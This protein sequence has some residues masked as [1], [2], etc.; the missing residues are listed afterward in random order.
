MSG[1]NWGWIKR[2][3]VLRNDLLVVC[4]FSQT[5]DHKKRKSH[6]QLLHQC[7]CL[8][9][10]QQQVAALT[11]VT[12]TFCFLCWLLN[13]SHLMVQQLNTCHVKKQQREAFV[14]HLQLINLL[15]CCG[16]RVIGKERVG[17]ATEKKNNNRLPVT[18]YSGWLLL[19]ENV[20]MK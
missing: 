16:C 20:T 5:T 1:T 3:V 14:L 18:I 13:N 17:I 2:G 4:W 7:G 11:S 15:V 12:I 9:S 8:F 10:D 19:K 6:L